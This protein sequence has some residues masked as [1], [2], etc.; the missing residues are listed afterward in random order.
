MDFAGLAVEEFRGAND[1]AAE[2][3]ADGLMPEAN[4]QD[5]KFPGETLDQLHGNAGLLGRARPRGN[6]NLVRLALGDF[7]DGDFVVAVH[8][9]LTAKLTEIL[10]QVVGKGVVVVEQQDHVI[11]NSRRAVAILSSLSL[12]MRRFEGRKQS[13]R[14]VD[15]LF[16]FAFGRGIGY[17]SAA[18]LYMGH[19]ILDDHGA[20][21]DA[22]V[23]I[24]GKIQV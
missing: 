2:G 24:P 23:K 1:F 20:Q 6:D 21:S 17:D 10:S 14:L 9:H 8:L 3:G 11:Q 7:L 18:C 16:V 19:A 4:A 12:A 15:G 22:G 13:L 5:R